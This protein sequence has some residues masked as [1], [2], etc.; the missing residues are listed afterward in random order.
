MASSA[1]AVAVVVAALHARRAGAR[2][3]SATV[4]ATSGDL[5]SATY[6]SS[7]LAAGD[8]CTFRVQPASE[9]HVETLVLV[10]EDLYVFSGELYVYEGASARQDRL[11]WTCLGCGDVL[12]PPFYMDLGAAFVTFR[13][14]TSMFGE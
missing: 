5:V 6:M 12:P 1:R 10:F 11:K 13:S 4:T 14:S 8:A 7:P 9:A 2:C 3:D